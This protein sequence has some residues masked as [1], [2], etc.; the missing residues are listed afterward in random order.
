MKVLATIVITI[1]ALVAIVVGL[2]L[3]TGVGPEDMPQHKPDMTLT[4][5]ESKCLAVQYKLLA[6]KPITMLDRTTGLNCESTG[7]LYNEAPQNYL[8]AYQEQLDREANE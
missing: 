2:P 3:A 6:G 5:E 4:R 8:R 7:V 1:A